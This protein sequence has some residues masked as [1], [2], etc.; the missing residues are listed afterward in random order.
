MADTLTAAEI[1]D[2][3]RANRAKQVHSITWPGWGVALTIAPAPPSAYFTAQQLAADIETKHGRKRPVQL[4]TNVAWVAACIQ[5]PKLTA[6]EC[7]ELAD[8]DP[9]EFEKLAQLC[10]AISQGTPMPILCL[11]AW[12]GLA[13]TLASRE[14][15]GEVPSGTVRFWRS[16]VNAFLQYIDSDGLTDPQAVANAILEAEPSN[17]DEAADALETFFSTLEEERGN[18]SEGSSASG[19]P[20]SSTPGGPPENSQPQDGTGTT[21]QT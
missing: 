9:G 10:E 4:E 13:D 5:E 2:K 17:V 19:N 7:Y 8:A 18:A 15:K 20:A 6:A 14:A 21:S 12:A 16:V 11:H 1:I 3:A